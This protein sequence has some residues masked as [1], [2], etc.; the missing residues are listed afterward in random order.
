M[1]TAMSRTVTA[2][3]RAPGGRP[4]S[5]LVGDVLITVVAA[6]ELLTLHG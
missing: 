4:R 6:L 2:A 5:A 1:S 3:P